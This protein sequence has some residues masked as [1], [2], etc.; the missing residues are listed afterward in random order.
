MTKL[1][2][3]IVDDEKLFI[4]G[5]HMILEHDPDIKVVFTAQNGAIFL[6]EIQ[7]GQLEVD[8]VLLDLSMPVL[9][10]IDTLLKVSQI[11]HRFKI[12]I[13]TSHYNN[14]MIIKLLDEGASAFLA[15]NENPDI[16]I[17]TIKKVHENGFYVNNNILQL[18]RNRR[19]IGKRKPIKVELTQREIEVLLLICKEYTNKEIA[20]K[21]YISSRT[22]EG[23]R[24]S[25]LEKTGCKNTAGMVIYAIE[26]QLLDVNVSK[27]N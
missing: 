6:E 23:H 14:G 5:M 4:K 11:P 9:D 17:E 22:V 25:I 7:N 18:L 15:K 24:K 19:L 2:V 3:A 12:I 27:Y 10:G 26:H 1:R 13:L 21:I 20:D 16:V 8:V